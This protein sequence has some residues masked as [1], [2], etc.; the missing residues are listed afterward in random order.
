VGNRLVL[1][2]GVLTPRNAIS[3]RPRVVIAG[4]ELGTW[5]A[6]QGAVEVDARSDHVGPPPHSVL[7]VNVSPHRPAIDHQATVSRTNRRR[8]ADIPL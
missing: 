4:D 5:Q 6:C 1:V 8:D 7:S 3:D 2:D